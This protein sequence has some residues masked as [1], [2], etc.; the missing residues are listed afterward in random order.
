LVG[1]RD[2]N[3][4]TGVCLKVA[5]N[6]A[7]IH[8]TTDLPSCQSC[9]PCNYYNSHYFSPHLDFPF[10]PY[11]AGAGCLNYSSGIFGGGKFEVAET[12]V[13]CLVIG[14]ADNL[15]MNGKWMAFPLDCGE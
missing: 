8:F 14:K 1:G 6:P 4:H 11:Y 15:E 3:F 13:A 5:S 7:N 12:G 9:Q 2:Y 10:S